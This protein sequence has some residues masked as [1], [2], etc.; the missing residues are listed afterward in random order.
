[1][2]PERRIAPALLALGLG[3][4]ALA[5]CSD[6]PAPGTEPASD[7]GSSGSSGTPTGDAGGGGTADSGG[8]SSGG[9]NDA[10]AEAGP[11][12]NGCTDYV[13]RTAE[14][15]DR[16]LTWDFDIGG[17]AERCMTVKVGQ[18]VV[19]KG[20]LSVHPLAVTPEAG[21]TIAETA[22]D[23]TVTLDAAGTYA[24]VCTRHSQMNGAIRVVP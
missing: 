8:T 22:E 10:A 11:S 2:R 3:L 7:A 12:V 24:F 1:M 23:A 16:E 5:A 13:D 15:A 4:V 14:G 20:V 6:D 21:R 9:A 18:R 19:F 17:Q